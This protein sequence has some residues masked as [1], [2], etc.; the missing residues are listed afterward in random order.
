MPRARALAAQMLQRNP[1]VLRYTR[2]ALTH[3]LKGLFHRYMGSG[4]ALE[5]LAIIDQGAQRTG[6]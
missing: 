5:G 6:K 1:L 2:L 4:A 3:D